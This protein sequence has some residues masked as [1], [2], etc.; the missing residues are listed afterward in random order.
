MSLKIYFAGSITG[1]REHAHV[2]PLLVDVLREHGTV[3]TEHVG[4]RAL[5]GAGETKLDAHAIWKRDV[6]W[7]DEAD[8]LVAEVTTPSLGVGYE[9]GRAEARGIRILALADA[10]GPRKLSAMIRGNPSVSTVVYNGAAEA[11]PALRA[12]LAALLD[13]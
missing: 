6:D 12:G 1:G 7:V 8:V 9:I 5:D 2:Y 10:S 13:R 4:D 3:L 11:V